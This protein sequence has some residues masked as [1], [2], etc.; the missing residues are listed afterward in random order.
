MKAISYYGT[1][2]P[3]CANT[4]ILKQMADEGMTGIRMNLSH[5]RLTDHRDWIRMIHEAGISDLLIDLQG[6]EL[7]IGEVESGCRLTEGQLVILQGMEAAKNM[8]QKTNAVQGLGRDGETA[9]TVRQEELVS[10]P[11]PA[12]VIEAAGIGQELL[13]D[14]GKLSLQVVDKRKK[15]DGPYAG[16]CPRNTHR[17]KLIFDGLLC[18]VMRGGPLLG[19]KS[20]TVPGVEIPSPTLTA[21]DH[22]NLKLAV[23]CGVTGVMLP[24]VRNRQDIQ[25]L[26]QVLQE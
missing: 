14:D 24:F 25:N 4:G 6:P 10:V 8:R 2:G 13:I 1:I 12:A 3:S 17:A 11:I 15:N 7:R 16:R 21:E 23:S 26:K 18:Q 20:L 9:K 19:R 22:E 5:G